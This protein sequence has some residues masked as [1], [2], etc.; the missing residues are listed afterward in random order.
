MESGE[1]R[2]TPVSRPGTYS[3]SYIYT[4]HIN[5]IDLLNYYAQVFQVPDLSY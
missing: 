3:P 1:G 2:K 5:T 4:K